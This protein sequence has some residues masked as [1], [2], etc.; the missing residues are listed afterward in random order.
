MR[1][2]NVASTFKWGRELKSG[3]EQII[4]PVTKALIVV[5]GFLI[6]GIRLLPSVP[7]SPE[8]GYVTVSPTTTSTNTPTPTPTAMPTSTATPLPTVTP[9][10]H[11][12]NLSLGVAPLPPT[13]ANVIAPLSSEILLGQSWNW[14]G[15]GL[16]GIIILIAIAI[17]LQ[18][19]EKNSSNNGQQNWIILSRYIEKLLG[20]Q[21]SVCDKCL[22][23]LWKKIPHLPQALERYRDA[24]PDEVEYSNTRTPEF[25]RHLWQVHKQKEVPTKISYIT[26]TPTRGDKIEDLMYRTIRTLKFIAFIALLL[27][28]IVI[29]VLWIFS[30]YS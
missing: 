19:F 1:A 28:I 3:Q 9:T 16:G 17:A 29:F 22:E 14:G 27:I 23:P 26:R 2:K 6:V 5:C 20:I 12:S 18:A 8:K 30:S 24:F 10:P 13:S 7:A 15:F 25:E 11:I 4:L 21:R